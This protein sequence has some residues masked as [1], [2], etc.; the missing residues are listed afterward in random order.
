MRNLFF[1]L[2]LVNLAFAAW[3]AW[4]V[5]DA[6]PSQP[7]R[8]APSITLVSELPADAVR[9]LAARAPALSDP[10]PA[11][12]GPPPDSEAFV[13]AP[14]DSVGLRET[15]RVEIAAEEPAGAAAALRCMSIG[16]FRELA[17]AAGAAS[18]LR[19]TGFMP[20][21]RVAEGD[22]WIGYWV[23]IQAIPTGREADAILERVRAAGLADSYVIPQSDS[24]ALVSL[25]V[26]TE[27]N[28]VT[29]RRDE[30]RALG[31][32]PTVVDRTRRA[33][34]YWVDVLLGQEQTLDLETLQAPGRILRLEL[35]ACPVGS[36]GSS[37]SD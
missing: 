29:R 13:T 5:S 21:Q 2:V 32:E 15:D 22:V 34:V 1:A 28:G 23:Y 31:Y 19:M 14:E 7:P 33:T 25:G 37:G 30:V 27:I 17:Q 11:P 36:A 26:F 8:A 18:S 4:F 6:P 35:R 3:R 24:G 20:T 10:P 9:Q 16:P 12:A